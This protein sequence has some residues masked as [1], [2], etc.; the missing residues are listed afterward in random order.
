MT[1]LGCTATEAVAAFEALGE[2]LREIDA[3]ILFG[4]PFDESPS[5]DEAHAIESTFHELGMHEPTMPD[6]RR[7]YLAGQ[8]VARTRRDK[9]ERL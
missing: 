4:W 1:D 8:I 6:S 3:T 7:W 2:V 9:A 5:E